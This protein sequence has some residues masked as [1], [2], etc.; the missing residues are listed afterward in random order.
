MGLREN[1]ADMYMGRVVGRK[2]REKMMQLC[3]NLKKILKNDLKKSEQ[4]DQFNIWTPHD[5]VFLSTN[6]PCESPCN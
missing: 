4:C 2:K 1:R 3:F 5:F 6:W